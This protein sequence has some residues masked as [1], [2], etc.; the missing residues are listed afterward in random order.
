MRAA[1]LLVRR[2]EHV[3]LDRWVVPAAVELDEL[4]PFARAG[5]LVRLGIVQSA[6]SD[7]QRD[8]ALEPQPA[9]VAARPAAV[10]LLVLF[11]AVNFMAGQPAVRRQT[12]AQIGVGGV[13]LRARHLRRS[14]ADIDRFDP[15]VVV[16][17]GGDEVVTAAGKLD[18]GAGDAVVENRPACV[19]R[20]L[21]QR[22]VRALPDGQG[23]AA[24]H[25][26]D[27]HSRR[28]D[29]GALHRHARDLAGY[30]VVL[31]ARLA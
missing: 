15:A 2:R 21:R 22:R 20:L 7:V 10:Q 6:L 16:R 13:K 5:I 25:L 18:C 11:G 23:G 17:V 8:V 24:Y 3:A 30:A 12:R 14:G 4:D 29:Q 9:F 19:Y 26:L 31:I 1:G 28:G 27:G